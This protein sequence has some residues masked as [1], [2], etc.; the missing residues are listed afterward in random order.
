[1]N[2]PLALY[3]AGGHGK[4]V[5][6]AAIASGYEVSFVIDNSPEVREFLGRSVLTPAEAEAHLD[7]DLFFIVSIGENTA[8]NRIFERLKRKRCCFA[9][10]FH[11]G[12]MISRFARFGVG[13]VVFAGAVV[14]AGAVIADNCIINTS[15]SIDHDCVIESDVHVC[16]GARLTGNVKIG[17]GS[18]IGTGTSIIPGI[19]IGR[20][21][22]IGA[23]SAVV[24]DIPDHSVALGVP[25]RVV[26]ANELPGD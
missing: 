23:G 20:N 6:D 21:C 7:K 1:M 5:Y 17:M 16:P 13:N 11:P 25:A 14:N 24:S 15:A 12:A 19:S 2:R 4:V 9:N 8:R 10:I 26:R 18:L 3:G 22:V